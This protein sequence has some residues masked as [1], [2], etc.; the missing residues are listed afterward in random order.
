MAR[1]TG[2]TSEIKQV[3][4]AF[5][6]FENILADTV[7]DHR[8]TV[9]RAYTLTERT[10]LQSYFWPWKKKQKTADKLA[11]QSPLDQTDVVN[12]WQMVVLL[13]CS[14]LSA[15]HSLTL[16]CYLCARKKKKKKTGLQACEMRLIKQ[17]AVSWSADG[18]QN[19]IW[20]GF[21]VCLPDPLRFGSW[22]ACP[23]HGRHSQSPRLGSRWGEMGRRSPARQLH[24]GLRFP[25]RVLQSPVASPALRPSQPCPLHC[26]KLRENRMDAHIHTHTWASCQPRVINTRWQKKGQSVIATLFFF[27]FFGR[28]KKKTCSQNCQWDDFCGNIGFISLWTYTVFLK[29]PNQNSCHSAS[30]RQSVSCSEDQNPSLIC[31]YIFLIHLR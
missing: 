20:L 11:L 24:G 29:V 10:G 12:D 19:I 30:N 2:S 16:G 7:Q 23:G 15:P 26:E 31:A 1:V 3:L 5:Y 6:S 13:G 25:K 14:F 4:L 27:F 22:P 21:C 17:H 28:S 9:R 18:W 8:H